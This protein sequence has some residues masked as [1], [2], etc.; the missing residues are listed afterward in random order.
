[1]LHNIRPWRQAS[2]WL[3]L[4]LIFLGV[5]GA[6]IPSASRASAADLEGAKARFSVKITQLRWIAY[7]PSTF[8][9]SAKKPLLRPDVEADLRALKAAGFDGIV[10]YSCGP[11]SAGRSK[12]KAPLPRD[13]VGMEDVPK[14][15]KDLGFRGFIAGIWDPASGA[16]TAAVGRLAKAQLIDAVCV[17]NEGLDARYDWEKLRNAMRA[18]RKAAALPVTTTE[19]LEDYG[20]AELRDPKE[21][22][23]L[24]P[25]IHPVFN[26]IKDPEEAAKWTISRASDL[27]KLAD[28]EAGEKGLPILIKETGWPT[29]GLAWH[30]EASQKLFWDTCDRLAKKAKMPYVVFEAFDQPWK[31][32]DLLGKDIGPFWGVFSAKREPKLLVARAGSQPPGVPGGVPT[33][34]SDEVGAR[35]YVYRDDGSPREFVPAGWMPD[36]TGMSMST[37]EKDAP[38]SPPDCIRIRCQL[39]EK[40]WL[41]VYFLLQGE[42]EPKQRFNL[43]EKLAAKKGDPI[44]CRFWARSKDKAVVQFKVGGV[45]KGDISDSLA[46]PIATNWLTLTPDWK[47]YE[48]DLTGKDLSSLVGGFL[49]VCD[50]AHNEERDINFDLDTIYFVRVKGSSKGR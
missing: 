11:A 39:S 6:V 41:G 3:C 30:N 12:D 23:W 35:T 1:M 24:F 49:W 36:G 32:E 48:I 18:V 10:T 19:Q 28:G 14:M 25:N 43:I 44:T 45:T 31:H 46:F 38:H 27:R 15:A 2:L 37:A 22:D 17:G 8:D 4:T 47:R 20:A 33:A 13:A 42:W 16:E 26:N 29:R 40:P 34:A 7:S 21:S 5:Q 9:P 50:R